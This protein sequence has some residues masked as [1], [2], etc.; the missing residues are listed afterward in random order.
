MRCHNT[1]NSTIDRVPEM[2]LRGGVDDGDL[3]FKASDEEEE[4]EEETRMNTA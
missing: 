2:Q 4:E 3:Y 1:S